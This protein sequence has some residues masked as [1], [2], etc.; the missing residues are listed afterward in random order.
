MGPPIV[1][2]HLGNVMGEPN[3]SLV[4]DSDE[5]GLVVFDVDTYA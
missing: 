5:L 2:Q 4:G 3:A 1:G